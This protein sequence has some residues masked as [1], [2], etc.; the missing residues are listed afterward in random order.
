MGAPY[1]PLAVANEFIRLAGPAGLDHMKLQKLVYYVQGLSCADGDPVINEMPEVWKY[2]PVFPSL[3]YELKYHGGDNIHQVERDNLV[4][5]A[6]L[7][8]RKD[9]RTL[10]IINSVWNKF[11]D[12]TAVQLSAKTH[13][14]GTPWFKIAQDNGWAVP[15]HTE[16]PCN[17]L[18]DYFR[19]HQLN[20]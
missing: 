7:I 20:D 19:T 11:K 5:P 6:P 4:G 14:R 10:T 1:T 13:R 16:I 2:G 17:A 18:R 8:D 9:R 15:R 3:Y 12:F